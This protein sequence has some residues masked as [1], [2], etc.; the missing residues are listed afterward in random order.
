VKIVDWKM[1][2]GP[3]IIRG[4]LNSSY[5]L[6]L[7]TV[8]NANLKA[9]NK[10]SVNPLSF[11]K[12][13]FSV[14]AKNE[15]IKVFSDLKLENVDH[16]LESTPAISLSND[17]GTYEFTLTVINQTANTSQFKGAISK[18]SNLKNEDWDII[19][20]MS[21]D[22]IVTLSK[23]Y[24]ATGLGT[25]PSLAHDLEHGIEKIRQFFHTGFDAATNT[26]QHATP[27]IAVTIITVMILAAPI[28]A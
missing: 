7:E 26:L 24:E 8:I 20:E 14:E 2:Q 28:G 11:N 10:N 25:L 6:E 16:I 9:N 5:T 19:G 4:A 27:V 21:M 18:S 22:M 13:N 1:H 17:Y 3:V 12:E 23:N 15:V